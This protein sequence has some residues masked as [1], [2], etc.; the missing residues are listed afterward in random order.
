M[1][2]HFP[3]V[4]VSAR[5]VRCWENTGSHEQTIKMARMTQRTS[6]RTRK[7]VL[8]RYQAVGGSL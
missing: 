5:D 4:A 3:E 2:W 6:A 7:C 8:V 1:L